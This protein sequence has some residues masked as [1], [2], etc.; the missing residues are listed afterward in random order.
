MKVVLDTNVLISAFIKKG[1]YPELIV[2]ACLHGTIQFGLSKPLV[3][4]LGRVFH[5]PKL[6]KLH[7]M[8]DEQI[9]ALVRQLQALSDYVPTSPQIDV[10]ASDPT[11]SFVLDCALNCHADFIVT[12]DP[13]LLN[14][15]EYQDIEI[16]TPALCVEYIS[17]L[18]RREKSQQP[19]KS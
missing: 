13:H 10:L 19:R 14:L 5:K 17:S 15:K 9:S 11:D 16:I 12:G 8:T 4:E 7:R 18:R 1:T 2:K 3:D 6:V